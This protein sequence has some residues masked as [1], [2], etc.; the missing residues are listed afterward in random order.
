MW[1]LDGTG[2]GCWPSGVVG[3][4]GTACVYA[5]ACHSM[6]RYARII[7]SRTPW[8]PR[9]LSTPSQLPLNPLS[10][11]FQPSQLTPHSFGTGTPSALQWATRGRLAS[12]PAT[13]FKMPV[14]IQRFCGAGLAPSSLCV[15]V[16]NP[17]WLRALYLCAPRF[18]AQLAV[19]VY[20]WPVNRYDTISDTVRYATTRSATTRSRLEI[21]NIIHVPADLPPSSHISFRNLTL[22]PAASPDEAARCKNFDIVMNHRSGPLLNACRG[23]APHPHVTPPPHAPC[24]MHCQHALSRGGHTARDHAD[25]V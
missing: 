18:A 17:D 12:H 20:I 9:Y 5:T 6:P 3:E 4:N 11:P 22:W 8:G 7:H 10:T 21:F 19:T 1:G 23:F 25:R 24:N 2:R 14:I 13:N 16:A 15:T